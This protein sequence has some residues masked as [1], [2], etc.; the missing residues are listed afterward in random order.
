MHTVK[1]HLYI[2]ICAREYLLT[3]GLYT[4]GS[5]HKCVFLFFL[6]VNNIYSKVRRYKGYWYNVLKL[7]FIL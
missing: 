1:I 2:F 7:Y 5:L 6:L 3:L 4:F